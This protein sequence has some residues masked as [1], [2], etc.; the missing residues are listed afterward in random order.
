[1]LSL[2]KNTG[3][4]QLADVTSQRA[5]SDNGFA[6]IPAAKNIPQISQSVND[7]TNDVDNSKTSK[8][9]ISEDASL[10]PKIKN[11]ILI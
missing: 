5:T 9:T 11:A 7:N 1:M 6:Y 10:I 2:Y 8:E 4:E 3:T